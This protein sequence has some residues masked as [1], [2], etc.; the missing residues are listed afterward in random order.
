MSFELL[1]H[2]PN[3]Y[4]VLIVLMIAAKSEQIATVG[5]VA[6]QMVFVLGDKET[7][8]AAPIV[9]LVLFVE[10]IIA[11]TLNHAHASL[12]FI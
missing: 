8:T 6:A 12:I 10:V 2:N 5:T 3:Y 4:R 1:Y 7:V 9:L 11:G